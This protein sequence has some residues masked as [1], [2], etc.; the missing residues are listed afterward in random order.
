MKWYIYINVNDEL[1]WKT[2]ERQKRSKN[3]RALIVALDY[4]LN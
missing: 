4:L 3:Q 1:M 2:T